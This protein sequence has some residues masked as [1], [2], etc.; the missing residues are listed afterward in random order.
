MWFIC[1]VTY[2]VLINSI[3]IRS[4]III[5]YYYYTNNI[6]I[7][8][9]LIELLIII[10][11]LLLLLQ[12]LR[13]MDR[14]TAS[15][16]SLLQYIVF[17]IIPVIVDL[18]VAIVFFS[19]AFNFIFGIIVFVTMSLYLMV[20]IT[21]TEWRTKVAFFYF[22]LMNNCLFYFIRPTYRRYD[23]TITFI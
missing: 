19:T 22:L 10:I 4:I 1:T 2:C 17:R 9:L 6:I 23:G 8:R 18:V 14:G 20:T 3:I 16:N 7:I 12:V 21:I 15:I 13:V 11:T 5:G